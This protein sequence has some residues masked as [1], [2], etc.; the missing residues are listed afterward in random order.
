M[1][2]PSKKM[3]YLHYRI[4]AKGQ[5][6]TSR[7][8]SLGKG[9][10]G[11]IKLFFPRE[12][13]TVFMI[14]LDFVYALVFPRPLAYVIARILAHGEKFSAHDLLHDYCPEYYEKTY[15]LDETSE[16]YWDMVPVEQIK[17]AEY[18]YVEE[19][20]DECFDI[21]E[22]S[23]RMSEDSDWDPFEPGVCF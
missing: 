2:K 8:E 9:V 3:R 12:E 18:P 14:T 15:C 23:K 7:V 10:E 6:R 16:N 1:D 11:V 20:D 5:N 19:N 17:V 4:M 13:N 22:E 21:D